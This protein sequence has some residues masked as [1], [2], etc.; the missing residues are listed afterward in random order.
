M[1]RPC[2]LQMPSA[3][4]ALV[5]SVPYLAAGSLARDLMGA[6]NDRFRK[7]VALVRQ[8]ELYE[9]GEIYDNSV[10][11]LKITP[12]VGAPAKAAA[13]HIAR[14]HARRAAGVGASVR[15]PIF[16]ALLEAKIPI[17][18]RWDRLF[19]LPF[20]ALDDH[21]CRKLVPH[22]ADCIGA[23]PEVR[24]DAAITRALVDEK[25]NLVR[26][27]LCVLAIWPSAKVLECM[28]AHADKPSVLLRRI[29]EEFPSMAP[30]AR[31][32]EAGR[33][34]PPALRRAAAPTT[35]TSLGKLDPVAQ[36]QLA[37][38]GERWDGQKLT[39]AAR[40]AKGKESSFLG[41]LERCAVVTGTGERVYDV[42]TYAGDSGTIFATG[43]T[44]VV[45]SIIQ[46]SIECRNAALAE[47]L[48]IALA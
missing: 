13:D 44:R 17:E 48:E 18:A 6:P 15:W 27:G 34:P 21:K 29:A 10:A 32:L 12:K 31:A 23:I 8:N 33:K 20:F 36:K 19:P 4:R 30:I 46:S 16:F 39:A 47:G 3:P 2:W 22:L 9:A 38:A 37:V 1:A 40:L 35:I 11:F 28:L 45:A 14:T 43:T 25:L 41:S 24:R 26:N 7:F 42:F 5:G